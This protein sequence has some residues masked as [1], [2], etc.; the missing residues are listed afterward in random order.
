MHNDVSGAHK[1]NALLCLY[2]VVLSHGHSVLPAAAASSQT[3][4]YEAVMS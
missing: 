3:E 2:Q 1:R 4:E